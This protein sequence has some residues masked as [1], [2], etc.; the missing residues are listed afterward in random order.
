MTGQLYFEI[1]GK[2]TETHSTARATGYPATTAVRML[3]ARNS[4]NRGF[5][6]TNGIIEG[7]D[8]G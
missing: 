7:S 5:N 4:A 6:N 2:G 3:A 8:L 1:N